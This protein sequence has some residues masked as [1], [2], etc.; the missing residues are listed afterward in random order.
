MDQ[1]DFKRAADEAMEDKQAT[2]RL[3][4]ETLRKCTE[5]KSLLPAVRILVPAACLLAVLVSAKVSGLL[6]PAPGEEPPNILM[7][8][9]GL[10]GG[11]NETQ[12]ET[13]RAVGT[14]EEAKELF[15]YELKVPS[16]LPSGF[17]PDRL[18][19]L[20]TADGEVSKAIFTYASDSSSFI[21]MAEKSELISGYEG[22]EQ[23]DING[24]TG[25]I[26]SNDTVLP[27]TELY[28]T[29]NGI[30]YN[31]VGSVTRDG[32]IETALSMK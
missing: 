22:Y 3:K 27:D 10:P 11:T 21:L 6:E 14:Y 18:A 20:E 17:R 32:A 31:I 29:D 15:G 19:I 28:W 4:R 8:T 16:K 23:A 7:E 24:I 9:S 25:Y 1:K 12:A 2:D 30:K 13:E 26:R 5:K